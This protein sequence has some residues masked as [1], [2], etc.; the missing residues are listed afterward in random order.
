MRD[1]LRWEDRLSRLQYRG[2]R[3]ASRLQ[4]ITTYDK[5]SNLYDRVLLHHIVRWHRPGVSVNLSNRADD[6]SSFTHHLH[7]G[8]EFTKLQD[9]PCHDGL[10]ER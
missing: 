9:Y 7:L 10:G 3:A 2:K 5:R 8:A 1:F 4:L 6:K